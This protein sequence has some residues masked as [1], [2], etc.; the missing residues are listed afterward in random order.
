MNMYVNI[1]VNTN[2]Q[3]FEH[4]DELKRILKHSIKF[5]EMGDTNKFKLYDFNGNN[6]G[7]IAIYSE[8]GDEEWLYIALH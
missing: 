6:V 5:V 4:P 7:R 1:M 2:N 8:K 3:A